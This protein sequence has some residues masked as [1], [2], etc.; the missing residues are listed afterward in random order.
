MQLGAPVPISAA[1][2]ISL[3]SAPS[4]GCPCS[5]LRALKANFPVPRAE[6]TGPVAFL[7]LGDAAAL[8]QALAVARPLAM[9]AHS[10]NDCAQNRQIVEWSRTFPTRSLHA[11]NDARNQGSQIIFGAIAMYEISN[12]HCHSANAKENRVWSLS[13]VASYV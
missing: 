1:T 4:R 5:E 3:P 11:K 9:R 7:V 10:G 6:A 8:T 12:N 13:E 2:R